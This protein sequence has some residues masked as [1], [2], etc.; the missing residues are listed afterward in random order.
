[1]ISGYSC[2]NYVGYPSLHGRIS[3]SVEL[4]GLNNEKGLDITG[5]SSRVYGSGAFLRGCYSLYR[6]LLRISIND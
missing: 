4:R 6:R 5:L 3:A 2:F 1:M